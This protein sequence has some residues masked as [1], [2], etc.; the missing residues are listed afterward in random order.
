[1]ERQCFRVYLCVWFSFQFSLAYN[2]QLRLS[3]TTQET[4][5]GLAPPIAGLVVTT[6]RAGLSS[7]EMKGERLEELARTVVFRQ[8]VARVEEFV[9]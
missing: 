6:L 1:M 9:R 7:H 4:G 5:S 2:P 8:V 3:H